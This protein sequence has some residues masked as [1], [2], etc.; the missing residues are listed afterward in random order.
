[1]DWNVKLPET[2]PPEGTVKCSFCNNSQVPEEQVFA[3]PDVY[4]CQECVRLT[5]AQVQAPPEP[6][7][8]EGELENP[9]TC[10]FCQREQEFADAIFAANEKD[11]YI[12]TDCVTRFA[13]AL[14]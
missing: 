3:G 2:E 11:R 6:G 1:M 7:E 4:I 10:N 5:A 14:V 9:R 12:C 13:E 8:G